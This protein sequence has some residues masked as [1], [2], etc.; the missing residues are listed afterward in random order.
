M[1]RARVVRVRAVTA[2]AALV[3]AL[4]GSVRHATG[5]DGRLTDL[6]GVGQLKTTFNGDAG[7]FRLVLL[8]S[9]T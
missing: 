1:S 4:Y 2:I 9:P 6:R 8:L 5:A 3:L 7:A